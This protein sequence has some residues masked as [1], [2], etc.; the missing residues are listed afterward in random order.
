[1]FQRLRSRGQTPVSA[2]VL[3]LPVKNTCRCY[4]LHKSTVHPC[5][6]RG[7][8]LGHF[9][10]ARLA[11]GTGRDGRPESPR[12]KTKTSG[13]RTPRR[14]WSCQK[15]W[16]QPHH[17]QSPSG[18]PAIHESSADGRQMAT[19]QHY[20]VWHSCTF[21][22]LDL[23]MSRCTKL[24]TGLHHLIKIPAQDYIR[25]RSCPTNSTESIWQFIVSDGPL[26]YLIRVKQCSHL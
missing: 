25:R 16:Q 9:Q 13:Q 19:S 6:A 7:F 18:R 8:G 3:S 2:V 4:W 26:E 10:T 22:Q 1:M 17:R 14:A 11:G 21:Y 15:P 5:T 24:A 12:P 20:C 23:S